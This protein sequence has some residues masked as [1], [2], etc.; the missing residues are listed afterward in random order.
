MA[1]LDMQRLIKGYNEAKA[2]QGLAAGFVRLQSAPADNRL[3]L[4]TFTNDDT[5]H[6]ELY[7]Q[8]RSHFLSDV[9]VACLKSFGEKSCPVCDYA[10]E[11]RKRQM[12][13]IAKK[14]AART[15]YYFN[16][17]QDGE[18][19]ILEVGTSVW[20]QIM[21]FFADEEYGNIADLKN[22]HD[23]KIKKEGSGINTEYTVMASPTATPCGKL[24]DKPKDL[25]KFVLRK[26][27]DELE[28]ILYSKFERLDPEAGA[29]EAE[30][31]GEETTTEEDFTAAAPTHGAR[32]KKPM[33]KEEQDDWADKTFG[34]KGGS[35]KP[36]PA[37]PAKPSPAK[38]GKR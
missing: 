25:N 38:P 31:A 1:Q 30:P 19:R 9:S 3:R 17:L 28:E 2:K 7:V 37:K 6:E 27:A 22:G 32:E 8:Y 10:N 11:L 33:S 12:G 5:G 23:I 14:M 34:K 24:P 13:T 4:V 18:I 20:D 26:E 15:R 16:V 29:T 21:A 35:A 36:S